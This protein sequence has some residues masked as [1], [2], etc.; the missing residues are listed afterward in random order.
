VAR[1]DDAGSCSAMTPSGSA[2]IPPRERVEAGHRLVEISRSGR[3]RDGQGEGELGALAPESFPA[4]APGRRLS[5]RSDRRPGPGPQPGLVWRRSA[6][7]R[8]RTARVGRGVL[9]DEPTRASCDGPS[10]ASAEDL[11]RADV[12]GSRPTAI[13]SSVVLPAP[14]GRQPD[15]VAGRDDSVQSVSAGRR[16]YPL[17]QPWPAAQGWSCD[18]YLLV[19][20]RRVGH[21]QASM[22]SASS[23]AARARASQ[24]ASSLAEWSVGGQRRVGQGPGDERATPGRGVTIPSYSSSRT[25]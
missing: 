5:W 10:P 25:P 13:W 11:D 18:L 6:G 1:T 14:F 4:S 9:G 23:P 8:R 19:G 3:F 15:D 21:E 22:L 24:A 20:V 12:R 16:P 17:G 2:G 7:D